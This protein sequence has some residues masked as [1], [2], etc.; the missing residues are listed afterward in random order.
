MT[1]FILSLSLLGA[2]LS[3]AISQ[4]GQPYVVSES[5]NGHIW[6]IEDTN[7]DGDALDVGERTLWGDGFV[8]SHGMTADS[9]AVYVTEIALGGGSNQVVRLLDANADGDALDVGER[10]IWLDGL[11]NP[12][13]ISFDAGGTWYLSE[14]D[15]DQIWRLVDLNNDNDVLDVGEKLLFADGLNGPRMILPQ[16]GTLLVASFGSSQIH[17]LADLNGDGDALDVAENLV[18]TPNYTRPVGVLDDGDGGFYFT[19]SST[20]IV[21]HAQDTNGD[22]DMLDVA[23]V[24]SYADSV[25]GLL[26]GPF[27]LMAFGGGGFLLADFFNNQVKLVRDRNGDGDALDL[28]EVVLFADGINAPIDIV[29]LPFGL[30][31]DFNFDG[32]VDAADYVVWREGLGTTHTPDDYNIWSANFGRTAGSG[33]ASNPLSHAAVPEP[34]S[35][36]IWLAGWILLAALRRRR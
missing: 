35:A 2:L 3:A 11:D 22:G 7:G 14:F 33:S 25:Y 20:D 9:S 19:S 34:I 15:N 1:R 29:A 31:G 26:N 24:L 4:A 17:R 36:L 18:I 10:T 6:R 5:A 28:G 23:E 32:T 16:A 8:I 13:D 12:R 27:G 30:P 21:Y